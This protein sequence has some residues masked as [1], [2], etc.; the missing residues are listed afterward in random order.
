[1]IDGG[2]PKESCCTSPLADRQEQR[3]RVEGREQER[4]PSPTSSLAKRL[5]S[6]LSRT[7]HE[8]TTP[9]NAKTI[10]LQGRFRSV[11][12]SESPSFPFDRVRTSATS[13]YPF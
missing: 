1:M 13:R 4:A 12:F 6:T 9:D 11:P 10:V 8:A 7:S 2:N 3:E 5:P